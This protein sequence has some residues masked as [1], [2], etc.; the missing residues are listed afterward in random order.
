[1]LREGVIFAGTCDI[2]G[3]RR[4]KGFPARALKSRADRD[5]MIFPDPPPRW[6]STSA[7]ARRRASGHDRSIAG[8]R[9]LPRCHARKR[10]V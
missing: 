5:L 7:T 9:R 6:L 2:A 1:M 8:E 10:L 4:G 3:L